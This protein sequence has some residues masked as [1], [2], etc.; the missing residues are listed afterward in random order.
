MTRLAQAAGTNPPA[1]GQSGESG[2]A[3]PD[4]DPTSLDIGTDTFAV[5]AAIAVLIVILGIGVRRWLRR[6]S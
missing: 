6:K 3:A 4:V 2:T 1:G 5:V